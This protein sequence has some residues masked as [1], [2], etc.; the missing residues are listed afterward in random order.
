MKKINQLREHI[1]NALSSVTKTNAPNVYD[2]IQTETGYK[3][4]EDKIIN[5]MIDYDMTASAC[6][7][8]IENE[9]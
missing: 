9:L 6:I 2:N 7:P 8:H 3:N 1:K 5:M 4:I